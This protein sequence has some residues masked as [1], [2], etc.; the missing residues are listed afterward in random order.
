MV[1]KIG[2]REVPVMWEDN[3]SVAALGELL[4]LTIR[5]SMYG[6]FEQ[7]GSIGQSIDGNDKQI[8]TSPGDIVLY[9][10]DQIVIFYGSNSW[11]YT[12][13]GH[14]DLSREEI[15]ALLGEGDVTVTIEEG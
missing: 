13:L 11:S 5:M 9:S 7:V 4:P 12:S 15:T 2:D 1:L 6:G 8:T 3:P 10:G 14:I